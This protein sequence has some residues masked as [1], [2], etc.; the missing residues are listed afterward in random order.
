[1]NS[2][3]GRIIPLMQRTRIKDDAP[4]LGIDLQ[5]QWRVIEQNARSQPPLPNAA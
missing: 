2:R 5:N 4:R 3:E 1:M